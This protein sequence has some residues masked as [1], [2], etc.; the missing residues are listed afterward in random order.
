MAEELKRWQAAGFLRKLGGAERA[1]ARCVS[2]AFI[3]HVCPKPRLVI[4]LR[5]VKEQLADQPFKNEALPEFIASI[6]L[7]DHLI[8]WDIKDAFHL[9]YIHPEDRTN[10]NLTIDGEV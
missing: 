3:S 9:A 4:D 1:A 8:S 7:Y 5:D 10:L 2:P 6:Q